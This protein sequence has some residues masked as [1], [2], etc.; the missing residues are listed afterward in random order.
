[1]LKIGVDAEFSQLTIWKQRNSRCF[2]SLEI[3]AE[4]QDELHLTAMFLV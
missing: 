3:Y 4:D 1:M 2:E